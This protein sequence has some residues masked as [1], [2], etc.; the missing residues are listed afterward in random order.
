[1]SFELLNA[2][3]Q[4]EADKVKRLLK[5]YDLDNDAKEVSAAGKT[6][7]K[8]MTSD[9]K[10]ML[11][12]TL[13]DS[14][15]FQTLHAALESGLK[16]ESEEFSSSALLLIKAM[17]YRS[18]T[19]FLEILLR[20]GANIN[21]IL[22]PTKL[23]PTMDSYAGFTPL[24]YAAAY[25]LEDIVKTLLD[26]GADIDFKDDV[27]LTAL[28]GAALSNHPKIARLLL[29]RGAYIRAATR[30]YSTPLNLA[31]CDGRKEVALVLLERGEKI[32]NFI[33]YAT[34]GLMQAVKTKDVE[35]LQFI[36]SH[37]VVENVKE[38]IATNTLY[39][40]IPYLTGELIRVFMD[41]G[42][43]INSVND[44][45]TS[46]LHRAVK[47]NNKELIDDLLEF[48]ANI[49]QSDGN[50]ATPLHEAA[51]FSN[52]LIV[53]RLL[54]L[55]KADFN[56]IDEE[57]RTP[58]HYALETENHDVAKEIIKLWIK[59][60]FGNKKGRE[61]CYA[62]ICKVGELR[63][64]W[65][66]CVNELS[67]MKT[68]KIKGTPITYYNLLM[69]KSI[70]QLACY[71][72]NERLDGKIFLSNDPESIANKYPCYC[73][74]IFLQTSIAYSSSC[75]VKF[76]F[77]SY[78]SLIS[79]DKGPKLPKSCLDKIFNYLSYDDLEKL[80]TAYKSC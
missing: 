1:M 2:A 63:S 41:F 15:Y 30:N 67:R 51:K 31:I 6:K 72:A 34:H 54:Q 78:I 20:N 65:E 75:Q 37:E 57:G 24:Y 5:D 77:K 62:L 12:Y 39:S 42:A 35:I 38:E 18:S 11:L 19:I 71:A 17:Q 36:L 16:I 66:K 23:F 4:G 44:D 64:Y 69:P 68:E 29:D 8:I 48:G 80:Y 7:K 46:I 14:G 58:L 28:H 45:G 26:H 61:K 60:N 50:G 52:V 27:G 25:G 43:D 9:E 49:N 33:S 70:D 32:H 53:R 76:A 79:T 10:L 74:L 40:S 21:K 55:Y 22:R 3:L 13:V 73:G 56:A 47:L 59:A